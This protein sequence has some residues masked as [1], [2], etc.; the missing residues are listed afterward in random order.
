MTLSIKEKEKYVLKLR[1][2]GKSYRDIAHQLL[3]SPREISK[4]LKKANGELE[5]KE[6]KKVVLS[7]TAKA[8][9]LYKKGK[10]P[11]EVAIKR[12]LSPE[13]AQSL[14]YKY[15]SLN[16]L[17]HFVET[18]KEFDSYSFQNFID[19]Y[20]FMKEKGIGKK[21]IVEAIKMSID[22]PKIKKEYQEISDKLPGLQNEKDSY[23]IDNKFLR[24]KNCEL[25]D[26][27]N[28]LLL[29][30][31]SQSK[32]LELTKNE[33]IKKR[34]LLNTI[35]KS[36]DYAILK[37]KVE[38]QVNIFLNRKKELLK[39]AAMT[40]LKIIKEDPERDT[41]ISN[42]LEPNESPDSVYYLIS[43]EEEI[44]EIAVDTLHNSAL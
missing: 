40:I 6:R 27:C 5:E 42:I 39:L 43:Y 1:E 35:T 13:E 41:L 34:E 18:F 2:E 30:T 28:S 21:E 12:D 44:A 36:E 22:L 14:Y 23:I 24:G 10:S 38:E 4:I 26:E 33:L 31:K 15:L 29:K 7:N 16:K 19:Y 20:S 11:T 9:Q 37:N 17:Y 25:N 8:L 32:L 3:I